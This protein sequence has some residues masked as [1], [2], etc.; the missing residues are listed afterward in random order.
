MGPG[1]PGEDMD[2]IF[3]KQNMNLETRKF[4]LSRAHIT[5]IVCIK[6][7]EHQQGDFNIYSDSLRW[8]LPE[9]FAFLTEHT[10]MLLIRVFVVYVGTNANMPC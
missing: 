4:M 10:Y 6:V 8:I 1:G 3:V 2:Y 9:T 5:N 7:S